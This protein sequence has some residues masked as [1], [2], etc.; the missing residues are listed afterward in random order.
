MKSKQNQTAPKP[1]SVAPGALLEMV[2]VTQAAFIRWQSK[3]P[4]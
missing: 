2:A 3:T 1:L 4:A